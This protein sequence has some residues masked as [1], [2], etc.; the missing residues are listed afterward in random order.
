VSTT[1]IRHNSDVGML[2]SRRMDATWVISSGVVAKPRPLDDVAADLGMSSRT[3]WR[4]VKA[5][6]IQ[7][8]RYPGDRRAHIDPDE[9]RRKMAKPG[10]WDRKPRPPAPSQDG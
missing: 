5:L 1:E 2:D 6:G 10:P 8:H 9:V 7:K 4:L 3:M